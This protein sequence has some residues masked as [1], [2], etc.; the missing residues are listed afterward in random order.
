MEF[1]YQ[2]LISGFERT[3]IGKILSFS[4]LNSNRKSPFGISNWCRT[5]FLGFRMSFRFRKL[6]YWYTLKYHH[7][8]FERWHPAL[9]FSCHPG[10][11]IPTSELFFRKD[12]IQFSSYRMFKNGN[13][14]VLL[15]VDDCNITR[16]YCASLC[17]DNDF[18]QHWIERIWFILHFYVF[19]GGDSS[20]GVPVYIYTLQDFTKL[21]DFFFNNNGCYWKYSFSKMCV[22]Y[23]TFL[24]NRAN[25][26]NC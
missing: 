20:I 17:F 18:C 14:I 4:L 11:K 3:N 6:S 19:Q 1:V 26:K 22:M 23:S 24:E 9:A 12:V 16:R 5:L 13:G 2:T 25:F 10:K 21:F 15:R 8:G 7:L